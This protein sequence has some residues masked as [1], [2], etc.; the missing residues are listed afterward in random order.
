MSVYSRNVSAICCREARPV[1]IQMTE[2]IGEQDGVEELSPR[3]FVRSQMT[4]K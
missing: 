4:L 3:A 2:L 1:H